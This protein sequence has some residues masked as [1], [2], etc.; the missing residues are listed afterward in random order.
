[1]TTK[2]KMIEIIKAEN[3]TLRLGDEEN[4]YTELTGADYDAVISEWADARLA[5]E[6]AI[7]DAQV[8]RQNKISAY[9]KL[10][11]TEMEIEALLPE[12]KPFIK[13]SA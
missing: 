12:P 3:P 5:K 8:L 6:Q 13:P 4:G 9:Q 7:A 2:E 1:M 11:L 10:G